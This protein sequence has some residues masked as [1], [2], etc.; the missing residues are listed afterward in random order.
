VAIK[1]KLPKTDFLIMLIH[2][3]FFVKGNSETPS[4]VRSRRFGKIF[5]RKSVSVG[6]R[7]KVRC[8][9]IKIQS[10]EGFRQ[11]VFASWK[12]AE[13]GQEWEPNYEMILSFQDVGDLARVFSPERMR[14]IQTVRKESPSSIRE[15]ARL[16]RRA[17]PNVQKDV[18]D[19]AQM[20]I[21]KLKKT[22]VKGQ[23]RESLKPSCPWDEFQV[24]V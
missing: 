1:N 3:W 18:Q 20:G 16:L 4:S 14:I 9:K 17:Q 10:M 6:G 24:A 8:F 13:D 2:S 22:K 12:A 23:K 21:L 19:L 15:L 7:M 11:D 5:S